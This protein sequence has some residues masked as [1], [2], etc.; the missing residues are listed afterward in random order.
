LVN[1]MTSKKSGGYPHENMGCTEA[2]EQTGTDEQ[3]FSAV[4]EE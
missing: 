1:E 2:A 3:Y 4:P